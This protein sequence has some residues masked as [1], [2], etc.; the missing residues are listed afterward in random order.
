[1][2][3]SFPAL[4]MLDDKAMPPKSVSFYESTEDS[5]FDYLVIWRFFCWIINT[6]FVNVAQDN[7]VLPIEPIK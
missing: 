3:G 5:I 7:M 2:N 4:A 6:E 1:M